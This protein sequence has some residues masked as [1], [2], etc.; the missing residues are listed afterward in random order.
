MLYDGSMCRLFAFSFQV[1]TIE[2]KRAEYLNSFRN[3]SVEGRVLNRMFPG[4]EDGW[5][6]AI[7]TKG[8]TVPSVYK[9]VASAFGDGDFKNVKVFKNGMPQTG[10]AHLR[11]KTVGDA[12]LVNTHPFV[13][14]VYSFAHNGTVSE[15]LYEELASRCEGGTDSERLFRKFL[16]IKEKG[17]L[18]THD[19]Y[20][21]ML[22]ETK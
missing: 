18:S 1:E 21:E 17:G 20:K 14:G 3:L 9:S 19:A 10:I 22:V 2:N 16:T 4:H 6:A 15:G 5:G 13:D 7:Y 12:S 11:K 8:E